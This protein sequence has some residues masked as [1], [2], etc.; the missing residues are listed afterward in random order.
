MMGTKGELTTVLMIDV[1]HPTIGTRPGRKER[2]MWR[3][4]T[5]KQNTQIFSSIHPRNHHYHY[6][7]ALGVEDY[8]YVGDSQA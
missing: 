6:S 8:W 1:R 5:R 2:I 4:G 3:T 7:E